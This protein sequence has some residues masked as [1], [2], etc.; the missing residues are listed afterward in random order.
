[1]GWVEGNKYD[2]TNDTERIEADSSRTAW[3]RAGIIPPFL[4]PAN[5]Q[6]ARRKE[7]STAT[8]D[9]YT[10][11]AAVKEHKAGQEQNHPQP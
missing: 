7:S 3:K 10:Y 2:G 6:E 4:L 1:M 9:I 8:S 11:P 5:I